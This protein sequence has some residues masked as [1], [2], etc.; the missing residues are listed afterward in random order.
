MNVPKRVVYA[1]VGIGVLLGAILGW[2]LFGRSKAS[3]PRTVVPAGA[4]FGPPVS[5]G[6]IGARTCRE[7]HPGEYA[8]YTGSGHSRTLRAAARKAS[9]LGI[10]GKRVDDPERKGVVWSFAVHGGKLSLDRVAGEGTRRLLADYAFGSG[11]H[12]TTFVSLK[13]SRPEN[14]VLLEHRLTYYR[15]GR[16][17]VTP[18]QTAV[19][20]PGAASGVPAAGTAPIGRTITDR[21]ALKCFRCH[22]TRTSEQGQDRLEPATMIPNVSCERCHGPGRTHAAAA[23]AGARAEAL[24]MPFGPDRWTADSQLRL[25]GQCHRHPDNA[26]AELLRSD[27]P[28]VVRFQP[29]GLMQSRCYQESHGAL[30]CT[31]CHDPHA[32]PSS[33]PAPYEAA[34]RECHGAQPGQKTCTVSPSD[35]CIRCHMP[36]RDSGQNVFFTDHWIRVHPDQGSK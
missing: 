26:R 35:G 19:P 2:L 27:L 30:A 9:A 34:C 8:A 11:H 7:C 6:Y 3:A 17:R 32:R 12:A 23:Q 24:V 16:F 21:E 4:E 22:S 15:D 33:D 25:C 5:G 1:L 14:P 20:R 29:V 31:T 28:G 36:R 18:G 13:E 10:D